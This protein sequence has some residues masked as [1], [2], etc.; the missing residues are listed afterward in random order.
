MTPPTLVEACCDSVQ[1]ARAAQQFGAGR[2]E[3]CG[4][5]DGGT[6]PSLGLIAR[7]RD[8]LTIPLHVMIRPHTNSFVYDDDDVAV[9]RHDIVAAKTL[10]V[11]GIVLGPLRGDQTVDE[12]QLAELVILARPMKVTF[13]RAFDR[14]PDALE[15]LEQMLM[16]DVDY[17]LTS[18]HGRTALE[19]AATLQAL[20]ARAGD[21]LIVLAGGHVRAENVHRILELSHVREVHARATDPTIVRDVVRALATR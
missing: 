12:S 3:L 9:M 5:G 18:G 1:T 20:Q 10:G 17:I 19:G 6:T 14:T 13:H 7:C 2:V 8:E 11:N 21:Q 16:L 4:P 15:A